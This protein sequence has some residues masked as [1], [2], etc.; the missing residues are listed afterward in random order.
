M[1]TLCYTFSKTCSQS[2]RLLCVH[3][4]L[5]QYSQLQNLAIHSTMTSLTEVLSLTALSL[6]PHLTASCEANIKILNKNQDHIHIHLDV[7]HLSILI[8]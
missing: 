4:P 3:S 5:L 2:A 8:N 6:S 1:F 7:V